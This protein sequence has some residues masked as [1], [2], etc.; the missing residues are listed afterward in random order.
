[1]VRSCIFPIIDSYITSIK[2]NYKPMR[3]YPR[4]HLSLI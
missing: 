4:R 1:M 3:H 2:R